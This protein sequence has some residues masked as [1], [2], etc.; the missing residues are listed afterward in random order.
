MRSVAIAL[1][2]T[3]LTACHSSPEDVIAGSFSGLDARYDCLTLQSQQRCYYTITP[4]EPPTH[5]LMVLHPAFTPVSM[6]ENVSHLAKMAVPKGYVVVYP[7]GIDRQWNDGRLAN[8]SKSYRMGIDDVTFL[9][10]ILTQLQ[11]Q[12]AIP[13]Q[14]TALAGMSNGGM[15]S[16]RMAC[17]SDLLS[18]T[19]TVGANLPL[20]MPARCNTKP[21]AML[22]V[23]GSKD[24]IVTFAGGTLNHSKQEDWGRVESAAT[25]M[26]FFAGRNG[27]ARD[28]YATT[29]ANPDIDETVVH[30]REYACEGAP[31]RAL[32]IE[33]M[34]HTWPGERSR[35]FS[36]LSDRGPIS[37]QIDAGKES[38][39]FF[40][41]VQQPL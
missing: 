34:G 1:L 9:N 33:G 39:G 4:K 31:L 7:E 3:L 5:L 26:D 13:P 22:M 25:T 2:L 36:F 8:K 17:E 23:F 19:A 30:T 16:L 20:G 14:K 24:D 11:G 41:A 12:Y 18:M 15:M 37:Q 35:L 38:L 28:Y 27:C 32:V 6:T 10:R 40:A 29:Q 21:K